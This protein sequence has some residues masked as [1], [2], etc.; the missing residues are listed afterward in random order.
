MQ[1]QADI[2]ISLHANFRPGLRKKIKPKPAG[3]ENRKVHLFAGM[4]NPMDEHCGYLIPNLRLI[5]STRN[6]N[7][8]FHVWLKDFYTSSWGSAFHVFA[9]DTLRCALLIQLI[10]RISPHNCAQQRWRG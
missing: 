10:T 3:D 8:C 2:E 4:P 6:N 1:S 9:V 7:Q 5:G